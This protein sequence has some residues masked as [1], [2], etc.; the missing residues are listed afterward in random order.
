MPCSIRLIAAKAHGWRYESNNFSFGLFEDMVRNVEKILSERPFAAGDR[1]TAAD[2][3]L[4]SGINFTM[5]MI[6]V[7]PQRPA[8]HRLSGADRRA[9]GLP[10]AGE[11]DAELTKTV[12]P[13]P[14]LRIARAFGSGRLA[15]ES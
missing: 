3:Q 10:P 11:R 13:P 5:N 12:T 9:A 14:Q 7:L 1:F 4:A 2:T 6:K 15:V 8:F